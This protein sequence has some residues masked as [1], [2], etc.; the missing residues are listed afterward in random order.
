MFD[1]NESPCATLS[2][3]RSQV[4]CSHCAESAA[5]FGQTSVCKTSLQTNLRQ[6]KALLTLR[7]VPKGSVA[8]PRL[9]LWECRH[10]AQWETHLQ[11]VAD[12]EPLRSSNDFS[13]FPEDTFPICG[14]RRLSHSCPNIKNNEFHSLH[15][16]FTVVKKVTSFFSTKP[17][18]RVKP[19]EQVTY[20]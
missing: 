1:V 3:P 2:L 17:A 10:P 8:F 5:H 18:L 20:H 9:C 16:F 12:P 7:C 15:E 6:M 19:H 11:G 14:F 13:P 4:R